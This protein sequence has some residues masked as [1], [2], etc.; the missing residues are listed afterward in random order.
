MAENTLT[1]ADALMKDVYQP[2]IRQWF[3]TIRP[4]W[5]RIQKIDDKRKFEGRRF[6]FCVETA[7]PQG[8]AATSEGDAMPAAG[9]LSLTNMTLAVAT[10]N[11]V[12]RATRQLMDQ[13]NSNTGAFSEA[14]NKLVKGTRTEMELSLAWDTVRGAGYGDLGRLVSYSGTTLTFRAQPTYVGLPGTRRI[15]KNMYVDS[16]TALSGGTQGA[17]N[18]KITAVTNSTNT[19]TVAAASGFVAGDYVFRHGA[20][21]KSPMGLSGIVDDGTI[22]STI[23]GVSRTTETLA[24]ANVLGN[25]GTL[26]AWTPE[27]MDTAWQEAWN[28]GNGT[29]PTACYSPTEIQLRAAS[30]I[31]N[32][33]RADMAEMQLDNG[34]KALSWTTPDGNKPWIVDQFCTPNQVMFV[35]EAD[36]FHAVLNDIQVNDKDGKTF[37][38]VDRTDALECWWYTDRNLGA[39]CFNGSTLL[40]DVSHTL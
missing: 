11:G 10:Y 14:M 39:E 36:L 33:R 30:Y 28:N 35:N 16:Y 21:G 2:G 34:F 23:Q 3:Q 13:S 32:D 40:K 29:Y 5:T 18:V 4:I 9:E 26:R 24:N 27:L 8:V 6:L 20:R 31:R 19:A 1:T 38:F 25:S 15:K 7:D 22:L 12:T 17:N 37:R